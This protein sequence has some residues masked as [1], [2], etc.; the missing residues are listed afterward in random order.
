VHAHADRVYRVVA[1]VLGPVEAEDATQEVF[2]NILSGFGGFEGRS[3]LST[4]IYRVATNVA[5]RRI[6]RRRRSVLEPLEE[7]E[8]VLAGGDPEAEASSEEQRERL[9]AALERL[10][11]EQRSVV[12]LRAMEGLPFE[13]VAR[14]LGIPVPTAQSRMARAKERLLL[15]LRGTLEPHGGRSPSVRRDGPRM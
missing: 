5:L 3:R 6:E 10:P 4:W 13:E 15:L 1:S 8:P 2:L 14:I 12:V 9:R 11:A 7:K